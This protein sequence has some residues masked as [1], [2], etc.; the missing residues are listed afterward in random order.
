MLHEVYTEA[1]NY[2][3]LKYRAESKSLNEDLKGACWAHI[4]DTT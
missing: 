4:I 3:K 2:F 1:L